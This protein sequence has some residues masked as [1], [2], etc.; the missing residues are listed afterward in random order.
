VRPEGLIIYGSFYDAVSTRAS[1]ALRPS[2]QDQESIQKTRDCLRI[3][4]E[5]LKLRLYD[6]EAPHEYDPEA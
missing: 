1:I 4:L 3:D 2:R 5:A 6:T